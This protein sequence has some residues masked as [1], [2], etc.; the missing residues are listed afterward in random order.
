MDLSGRFFQT[1]SMHVQLRKE[2]KSHWLRHEK[3]ASFQTEISLSS[4]AYPRQNRQP[5]IIGKEPEKPRRGI[6]SATDLIGF[7]VSEGID[8]TPPVW[9]RRGVEFRAGDPDMSFSARCRCLTDQNAG[10]DFRAIPLFSSNLFSVNFY[11]TLI[12]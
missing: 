10:A 8:S 9:S 6:S 11:A 4:P 12:A 2:L 5:S 3:S 1:V 7:S